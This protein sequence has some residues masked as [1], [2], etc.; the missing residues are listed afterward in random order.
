MNPTF[1]F[2]KTRGCV[3][4]PFPA[5]VKAPELVVAT[6]YETKKFG[7]LD[8]DVEIEIGKE[9]SFGQFW[10]ERYVRSSHRRL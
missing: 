6:E 2:Q 8:E 7:K 1:R 3:Q 5:E 9:E 4:S 10:I